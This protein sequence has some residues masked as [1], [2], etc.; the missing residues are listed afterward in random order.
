MPPM[1]C[2][3]CEPC[4]QFENGGEGKFLMKESVSELFGKHFFCVD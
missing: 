3:R 1:Q 2:S 4:L